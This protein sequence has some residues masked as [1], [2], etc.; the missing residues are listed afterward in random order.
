MT[1]QLDIHTIDVGQGESALL[2]AREIV[3]GAIQQQRTMLIDGGEGGCAST[4]HDYIA[5]LGVARLDSIL[6][7]HYDS[8]HSGGIAS[9]LIAD[10]AYRI[11][12][13]IAQAAHAEASVRAVRNQRIAY[14]ASAAM[15]VILGA[16]SLPGAVYGN[17]VYSAAA[18][19]LLAAIPAN[20][21]AAAETGCK[22]AR[23]FLSVQQNLNPRL[24]VSASSQNRVAMAAGV[25]AA[26]ALQRGLTVDATRSAVF[27]SLATALPRESRFE[28]G[29]ICANTRIIDIGDTPHRPANYA[30][31][32]DGRV[33][34]S[35]NYRV[36]APGIARN[37]EEDPALGSEILWGATPV[38]LNAP[39]V[40]V[41][42]CR[43]MVW[44]APPRSL[45]IA[46]GQPDNDDSIGLVIRFN[47]FTFYSGGD[48]PTEGEDLVGAAIMNNDL[49]N[50]IGGAFPRAARLA[51]FK[52]GH[53]GADTATSVAFLNATRPSAA[54]IS[55]GENAGFQHPAQTTVDHLH[56]SVDAQ[57]F[58]LTN[59]RYATNH[60]PASF[61]PDHP[62]GRDQMNAANNKSFL[63][64]DNGDVDLNFGPQPGHMRL[65]I[66]QAGSLAANGAVDRQFTV[67]GYNNDQPPG[68]GVVDRT[69]HN[70]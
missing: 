37:H 10:N 21:A 8:D 59:C 16:Y 22:S 38:P 18:A 9:L 2:V 24:L 4:V 48:L 47:G 63:F 30:L 57:Q 61:G 62:F 35:S 5:A 13:T 20:D 53:H 39:T 3:G 68:N 69:I 6:V 25:A 45:P 36:Q 54:V 46:S 11:A 23:G 12:D 34:I 44:R 51:A 49:P 27:R 17:L 1:W 7:S 14:G 55:C 26:D 60:V 41:V 56:D 32:V 31:A 70:Y 58:F 64:G 43:K 52:C 15:A 40:H 28:T 42:A 29:G 66:S 19:L 33:T 50:P 65:S 67:T